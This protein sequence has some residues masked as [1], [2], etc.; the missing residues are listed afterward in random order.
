ML[1]ISDEDLRSVINIDKE[2]RSGQYI[3]TCPWC[4]KPLHFYIDKKTQ[5]FE[6]KKC[7]VAGNVYKLLKHLDKTYL[8]GDK[9]VEYQD[10]I[11]SIRKQIEDTINKESEGGWN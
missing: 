10:K 7:W 6:C 1:K 4:F 3:C 2:T 9:S 11:D 5:V 8:I